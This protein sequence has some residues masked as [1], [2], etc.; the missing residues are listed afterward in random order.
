MPIN[1]ANYYDRFDAAD[2][3]EQHLF[4]A[5]NVLQSSELNEIQSAARYRLQRVTDALL[6]EG[7]VLSG[8]AINVD[9]ATGATTVA[10]G[11][12]YLRGAVR[13]VPAGTL[14]VPTSGNVMVGVYLTTAIITELEDPDLRDP[15]VSFRNYQDPGAARLRI[16]AVWGHDGDNQAGDFYPVYRVEEGLVIGN[17]PPP[18]VDAMAQIVARYD[19]QSAGGYY[20]SSGMQ[21][22]RLS[23]TPEGEQ[24][25]SMAAGVARVGGEEIVRQHA[26]R[27]VFAAQ[28]DTR[29]IENEP[30]LA[31]GGTERV[32]TDYHP[33][34]AIEDLSVV[35]E[36]TTQLTHGVSGSMDVIYA[37]DG[38]TQRTSVVNIVSCVQGETT[39]VK[40]VDYQLTAGKVDWSLAPTAPEGEPGVGNTYTCVFQYRDTYVPDP[41]DVDD[42]G[43]TVTGAVVG[44]EIL[45]SYAWALPRY[46]LLCL[47]Q[48]GDI[49]VVPGVSAT[50]APRLPDVPPGWLGIAVVRQNWDATT[51]VTNNATR[52]VPMN[53][54]VRMGQNIDTL[55]ALVAEERLALNLSQ[56]DL[57]AQKGV[58]ADPFLN[59]NLRDQGLTQTAA[60]I[61]GDLTLGVVATV[62]PQSLAAPAT[63]TPGATVAVVDQPLRTGSKKINPYDSF[64]PL[65]AG[66]TLFPAMDEWIISQVNWLSPVSQ[67]FQEP[68]IAGTYSHTDT[69]IT[70]AE[71]DVTTTLTADRWLRPIDITF[72]LTGFGPGESLDTVTFD[73]LPVTFAGLLL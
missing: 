40:G 52:M 47:S 3:Y 22:M 25:Y 36:E 24:V 50:Q 42:T 43:F 60:T 72:H 45:A 69:W 68:N 18:E 39:Y 15:A 12:L 51:T 56:R 41:T 53:Q 62:Y 11:A 29:D 64:L 14:T 38:V 17:T 44:T 46:D 65:P 4:R 37:P 55:F 30:H 2:N 58:F 49:Q 61:N 7:D 67:V 28:P 6:K 57:P 59:D 31:L 16:D 27:F 63:L 73:G 71:E 33:I 34:H 5:G 1:L 10:G 70:E 26:R 66:A 8:A 20:V 54:L 23:D 19:R 32:T 35:R 13:G 9:L 21:V 48:R